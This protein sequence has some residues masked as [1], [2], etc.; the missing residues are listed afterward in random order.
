MSPKRT[1]SAIYDR[2]VN[3]SAIL[4]EDDRRIVCALQLDG[5]AS[6]AGIADVLGLAERTA[7]RRINRL[8]DSGTVRVILP[9]VVAPE[10][11]SVTAILRVRVLKGKVVRIASALA[12]RD[13]VQFVDIMEDGQEIVASSMTSSP[14]RARALLAGLASAGDIVDIRSHTG[15]HRYADPASWTLGLLSPE[16]VAALRPLGHDVTPVWAADDPEVRELLAANARSSLADLARRS[17]TPISTLRRRVEKLSANGLLRT[18]TLVDREALGL[19]VDANISLTVPPAAVNKVGQA[20]AL[21]PG[22]HGVAAMTGTPN[23]FLAYYCAH[24]PAL[25]LFVTE[26]LGSLGVAAAEV[27]LVGTPVKR[28][29]AIL[30]GIGGS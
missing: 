30:P 27:S 5:R 26:T 6:A 13:D 1:G 2:L 12:R 25:H 17:S 10:T 20:L 4:D 19:K 9:Q 3:K 15:L 29:G 14:S 8:L 21:M 22:I 18:V 16:E 28:A 23:M 24:L 7:V 11:E